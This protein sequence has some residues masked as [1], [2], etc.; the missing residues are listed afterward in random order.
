[1][2]DKFTKFK[3]DISSYILPDRFTFPFY[4]EP[5][6]IALVATKELQEQLELNDGWSERFGLTDT[7]T[8]NSI[9]K[10][11]GV[12]VVQNQNKEL[13]YLSAVSGKLF[14]SNDH[15]TLVPPVFDMMEVDSF[16][17]SGIQEVN[18]LIAEINS[19]EEHPEFIDNLKRLESL[20]MDR[21]SDLAEAQRRSAEAKKERDL[22]RSEGKF[23]LF[24]EDF[25]KL[26]DQLKQESA[27]NKFYITNLTLHWEEKIASFSEKVTPILDK[28]ASLK[29]Q[30]KARSAS[31]QQQLF[32]QY[33]FLNANG[34]T[35]SVIDIFKDT[36]R[37]RP[38]AAAGECAAPKLLHY[39][40]KHNFKPI[41]LAEFWWGKSQ[42]SEI[43]THK[44]FYPAC[45]GKCKP[46]LGHMLKGL[47]VDDNPMLEHE[48]KNK[49]IE[50][51]FEDEFMAVINK[52][53]NL[54]SVPGV[55][56]KDSVAER[57][58]KKYPKATGPLTVHR[59]DMQTSG[60]L[61]IAKSLEVHKVLQ[62][63]F[64]DRTI[65]KRYVALLDGEVEA[66]KGVIEL[67]LRPDIEDRPRQL[68][69]Y[70]HGKS[71]KTTFKVL[72]RFSGRTRIYFYPITGRTHQLRVH[73]AHQKGLNMAIVGDDLYGKRDCR[74]HLHAESIHFKH[75]KT[76]IKMRVQVDPT[77]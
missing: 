27:N 34:D 44:N 29:T 72:E 51:L 8:E 47:A 56:I 6:P 54:L 17:N 70:E 59:L 12:L 16:F 7:F 31:L 48:G 58:K 20:E 75:P 67:P 28:I 4:Y 65:K 40:F 15:K 39:A 55:D 14:D 33:N 11:F 64:M 26:T 32:E 53:A 71:A 21:D 3:E 13:G 10:M 23:E 74:L 35:K 37:K 5:I 57:M 18:A 52:P 50:I 62:K 1:M 45:Q 61:L 42:K 22:R 9:G 77:F 30:R 19:L 49:E 68:V 66:D 38:P 41:A 46:I 76:N 43:R 36:A 2:S 24:G 63:Q 73:A 69:C 25:K 60:I